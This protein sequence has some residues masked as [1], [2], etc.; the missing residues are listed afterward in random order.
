M[1]LTNQASVPIRKEGTSKARRE[2]SRNMFV[3]KDGLDGN[4]RTC[5]PD[6]KKRMQRSGKIENLSYR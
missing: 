3:K 2:A 4:N 6:G 1:I 5:L